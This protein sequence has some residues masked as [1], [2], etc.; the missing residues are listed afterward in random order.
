MLICA[1][2]LKLLCILNISYHFKSPL[3]NPTNDNSTWEGSGQEAT[4][5]QQRAIPPVQLVETDTGAAESQAV[6]TVLA[7]QAGNDFEVT[8][9]ATEITEPASVQAIVAEA[10]PVEDDVQT[11]TTS[12]PTPSPTPKPTPNPTPL[13]TAE[14]AQA[15]TVATT[16]TVTTTTVTTTTTT[17]EEIIL[18]SSP[19]AGPSVTAPAETNQPTVT[20]GATTT[21]SSGVA[22]NQVSIIFSLLGECLL[23][24][25]FVLTLSF[26][27]YY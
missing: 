15:T 27:I 8:S 13:P 21:V 20:Q 4:P 12:S 2:N 10:P 26:P 9:Q 1:S 5:E 11:F 23:N 6:T 16:T 25:C 7:Q 24:S 14:Q 18:T 22:G 19:T 3:L 17:T